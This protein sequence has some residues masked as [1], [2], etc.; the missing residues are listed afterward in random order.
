LFAQGLFDARESEVMSKLI[1]A[2][3]ITVN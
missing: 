2:K 1:K 3:N